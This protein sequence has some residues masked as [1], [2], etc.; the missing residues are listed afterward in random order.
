MLQ[1]TPSR[2]GATRAV[3][4]DARR[5]A[6]ARSAWV[7]LLTQR[8]SSPLALGMPAMS[9]DQ[10]VPRPV[11]SCRAASASAS[12]SVGTTSERAR[13]TPTASQRA[14][15]VVLFSR[16][17]HLPA[18]GADVPASGEHIV[19]IE[20]RP[21]HESAAVGVERVE[22]DEHRFG[23][24][25][26]R[27][28]RQHLFPTS[29]RVSAEQ[30]SSQPNGAAP[31]PTRCTPMAPSSATASAVATSEPSGPP[32]STTRRPAS[33]VARS[34]VH[35]AGKPPEAS[36]GPARRA[37]SGGSVDRS[38]RRP[39]AQGRRPRS[40]GIATRRPTPTEVMT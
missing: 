28:S 15:T 10:T 16:A 6:A 24:R 31:V 22:I 17:R 12:P 23:Q 30:R 26:Q 25:P 9:P 4:H 33:D 29:G 1:G 14:S 3:G 27:G 37:G 38:R 20:V 8:T 7:G 32:T 18:P 39:S 21:D 40:Q 13:R 34:L 5:R 35:E 11:S 36:S 19:L 2:K